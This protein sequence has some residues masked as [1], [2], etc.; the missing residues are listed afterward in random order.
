MSARVKFDRY[1]IVAGSAR[2]AK[3]RRLTTAERHA[4]FL[5]VLSLAAQAP[6][7]GCL[8]VGD[9]QA[10]ETD[11]AGEADVT[12]KE[13]R[14][15]LEKLRAVGV[16]YR[17]DELG[18]DRVHDFE[19]WNPPPKRDN[20]SAERQKRYRERLKSNG[21]TR[22]I[23]SKIKD[24]V[25]ERDE[26]QCVKCGSDTDLEFHHRVAVVSGGESTTANLELRCVSC[27]RG[28]ASHA[29]SGD[30]SHAVTHAVTTPSYGGEVEEE[31]KT[32]VT[33]PGADVTEA[34][35]FTFRRRPVNA[36]QR[37]LAEAI[38]ADFNEQAR[39]G[40]GAYTATGAP[41]EDLK[42]ILGAIADATP[43][44]ALDEA[45]RITKWRLTHPFWQGRPHTGVVFGPN[46][47]ASNRES[48]RAP[49]GGALSS[50]EIG[51]ALKRTTAPTTPPPSAA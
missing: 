30:V 49:S 50:R 35:V 27:H 44:L 3:F 46:V 7:R 25:M 18:C 41:S 34:R 38:L 16:I 10:D 14:S 20:T 22:S 23:P 15:A 12:V 31:E 21:L 11:I 8:L 6:I 13:A 26:G 51:E 37:T 33:P 24:A 43:P 19:E 48:A 32:P 2:H 40:Y 9:L 28:A 39:T 45:A 1:M 17:D 4:F 29:P 36:D 47:F 42:R 5:G